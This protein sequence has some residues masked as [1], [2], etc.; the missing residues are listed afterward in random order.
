MMDIVNSIKDLLVKKVKDV[1][2]N[3][4]MLA[5][6]ASD[7]IPY[8]CH[9]DKDTILTKNG[10]LLQTIKIVGLSH[11]V[12][13]KRKNSMRELIRNTIA[14]KF[15]S[16]NISLCFH[17]IRKE[18]NLDHKPL[19]PSFM[20]DQ[21]HKSWV[22][23]NEW[24]KKFVNELYITVISKGMPIEINVSN[25][26]KMFFVSSLVT[27]HDEFLK[28]SYN[29][30]AQ[31]AD[32]LLTELKDYGA[33]K[34]QVQYD[35]KIGYYSQLV[36]FFCNII[37][38]EKERTP[39]KMQDISK[40]LSQYN[41]AFGGNALEVRRGVKKI[42]ATMLT[43]KDCHN[44]S[45]RAVDKFLQISNQIVVTQTMNF[46]DEK[47]AFAQYAYQD[48][49]LNISGDNEFA[50][51]T[52]LKTVIDEKNNFNQT[53]FCHGQTTIMVIAD[54]LEELESNAMVVAQRLNSFGISIIR[55]DINAENCF[56][57]QLP[58]NFSYLVRKKTLLSRKVGHFASLYNF[59]FGSLES[60]WGEYVT[61]LTTNL[62]TTYFFN[63]HVGDNG[64]TIIVGDLFSGKKTLLNFLLSESSK[65]NPKILHLDS[66]KESELFITAIGGVYK[67]FSFDQEDNKIKLNP[68]LLDDTEDNR[69]YLKYWFLYL[70]D[71][72]ADPSDVEE[73]LKV[74]EEVISIIYQAPKAERK[75]V[76]VDKFF[77]NP[78]FDALNKKILEGLKMWHSDGK[79]AH[80]FDNDVDELLQ[81]SDYQVFGI[82]M[83]AMYDTPMSMN[84]PVINYLLYYFKT[85]CTGEKPA[86]LAVTDG[87]RVFN[88]IYFEKNLSYILDDL[89]DNNSIMLVTASFSSEKVN[90]SATV[91][92]IY[93]QKMATKIF[94]SNGSSLNNVDEI[95]TLSAEERMYLEAFDSN[96]REFII[97]QGE[98]SMAS[99]MDLGN[100]EISLGILCNDRKLLKYAEEIKKQYGQDPN[101][102]VPK[103]YEYNTELA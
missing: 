7:F 88:S 76:N 73:Y 12:I 19:F 10:E 26:S 77:I 44:I 25:F 93:N 37:Q 91:G 62:G 14:T 52:G 2:S 56:W 75:L 55:E 80:I 59:P 63:F 101:V 49:I 89:G 69:E 50:E 83:T 100:F 33:V 71:K 97:R 81:N 17:T 72:Y 98:V 32:V 11:E 47:T 102:W 4:I 41:V 24:N 28:N 21:L 60:K 23:Q 54:T 99:A 29:N 84:L 35:E 67:V 85:Y 3:E 58:G 34:L 78:E 57:A 39:V 64:H 20:Q 36:T 31:L 5:A 74:I 53:S 27:E 6:P 51:I 1:S 103:L 79:Y 43:I 90:W 65:F 16:D 94:L 92:E 45:D 68:L 18:V 61:L 66:L 70:L 48:Y 42:F 95:F 96:T 46:V 86:I 8:A 15:L 82:D 9:Y 13:G 22:S 87:N 40:Q 38:L 30:L